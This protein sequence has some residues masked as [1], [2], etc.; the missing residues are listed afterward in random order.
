MTLI[1]QLNAEWTNQ[2]WKDCPP[3]SQ[4]FVVEKNKQS[5]KIFF[6]FT[7]KSYPKSSN[8]Q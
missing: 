1:Q 7:D 3:Q 4:N 6:I 8:K 5:K 2:G